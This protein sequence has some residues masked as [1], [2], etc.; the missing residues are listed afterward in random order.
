MDKLD[1]AMWQQDT[2]A[3]ERVIGYQY[4]LNLADIAE[5]WRTGAA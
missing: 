1:A 2:G 5:V 3:A 4:D